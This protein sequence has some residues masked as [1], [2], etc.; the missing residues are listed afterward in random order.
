MYSSL[1]L[2]VQGPQ[3]L[4]VKSNIILRKSNM[5]VEVDLKVG[6]ECSDVAILVFGTNFS[7]AFT[8]YP[9]VDQ[10]LRRLLAHFFLSNSTGFFK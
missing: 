9:L 6:F 2:K 5:Q 7:G 8:Q 3:G 10:L 4:S 1:S